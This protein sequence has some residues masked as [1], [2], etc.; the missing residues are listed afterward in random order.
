M[1]EY[2]WSR[3]FLNMPGFLLCLNKTKYEWAMPVNRIYLKY[4]VKNKDSLKLLYMLDSI[5]KRETH[6][7]LYQTSKMEF[8]WKCSIFWIY[9]GVW[10]CFVIRICQ[11]S[12]CARDTQGSEYAWVCSWIM[13]EYIWIGLKQ[14]VK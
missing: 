7:E 12:E 8:L 1:P 10:I 5:Y 14:N 11:G 9:H 6:S 4:N 2:G 13:L 3:M